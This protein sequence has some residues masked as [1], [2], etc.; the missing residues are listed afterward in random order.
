MIRD[1][2]YE[3]GQDK[4]GFVKALGLRVVVVVVAQQFL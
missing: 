1:K 2:T 3:V 4:G